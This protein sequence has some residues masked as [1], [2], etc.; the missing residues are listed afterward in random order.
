MSC[1][2]WR[3]TEKCEGQACCGDCDLCDYDPEDEEV[4]DNG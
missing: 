2:L 1:S 4:T 3:Y